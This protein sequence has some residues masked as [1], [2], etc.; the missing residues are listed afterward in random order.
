MQLITS[1]FAVERL[2]KQSKYKILP[3]NQ[4]PLLASIESKSKVYLALAAF[5]KYL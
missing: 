5:L 2:T 1:I 4:L 3:H